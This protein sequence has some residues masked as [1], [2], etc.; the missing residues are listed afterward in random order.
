[1][2]FDKC[3][4]LSKRNVKLILKILRDLE[5]LRGSSNKK[6]LYSTCSCVNWALYGTPVPRFTRVLNWPTHA[7]KSPIYTRTV[8]YCKIYLYKI[9]IGS[10]QILHTIIPPRTM[11]SLSVSIHC[12]HFLLIIV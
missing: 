8:C 9:L 6:T 4:N 10:L 11:K 2:D 3:H 7:I 5:R 1:M 12:Y